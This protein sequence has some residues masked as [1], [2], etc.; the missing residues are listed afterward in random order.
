MYSA[1]SGRRGEAGGGGRTEDEN[2]QCLAGGKQSGRADRDMNMDV[3]TR[4]QARAPRD[5]QGAQ[6]DAHGQPVEARGPAPS[7]KP[8]RVQNTVTGLTNS[9]DGHT[10]T[11]KATTPVRRAP[12]FHR[13]HVNP[14][15]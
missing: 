6:R 1:F 8:N 14:L 10:P 9:P 4:A 13:L 12:Q 3:D 2:R 5:E 11:P 7:Q 15:P